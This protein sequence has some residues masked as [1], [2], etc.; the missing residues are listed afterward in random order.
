MRSITVGLTPSRAAVAILV[1]VLSL[2]LSTSFQ[3][4][5]STMNQ[6]TNQQATSFA[7]VQTY[8]VGLS[9][10]P[11]TLTNLGVNPNFDNRTTAIKWVQDYLVPIDAKLVFI[12]SYWANAAN[13]SSHFVAYGYQPNIAN[14]LYATYVEGINVAFFTQQWSHYYGCP[15]WDCDFTSAYPQALTANQSGAQLATGMGYKI[16]TP[17]FYDQY[18]TDIAQLYK[19]YGNYTNWIGFGEGTQGDSGFIGADCGCLPNSNFDNGSIDSYAHSQWFL[20]LVNSTGYYVGTN[21]L[22]KIWQMFDSPSPVMYNTTQIYTEMNTYDNGVSACGV[23]S[24]CFDNWLN[25]NIAYTMYNLTQFI[26]STYGRHMYYL[27]EIGVGGSGSVMSQIPNINWAYVMSSVTAGSWIIGCSPSPAPNSC[28]PAN[29]W[30]NNAWGSADNTLKQANQTNFMT[31]NSFGISADNA[32]DLTPFDIGQQAIQDWPSSGSGQIVT[33]NDY[34]PYSNKGI[35]NMTQQKY[36]QSFGTV[37]SRMVYDGGFFG[38]SKDAVRLLYFYH[39]PGSEAVLPE[40]LAAGI[41][42]TLVSDSYSDQNYTYLGNLKQYNVIF[43]LPR[44][45]TNGTNT[46]FMGRLESFIQ[47]GGGVVA[48]DLGIDINPTDSPS[49]YAYMQNILGFRIS[50]APTGTCTSDN[51][52]VASSSLVKPYTSISLCP[53]WTGNN[54]APLSNES[55]QVVVQTNTG[56]PVIT[57]NNYG[58]GRGVDIEA[59]GSANNKL[60]QPYASPNSWFTLFI[61]AV[62]FAAHKENMLP[63]IWTTTYGNQNWDKNLVYS[64]DG[65]PGK[66]VLIWV[67][68]NDTSPSHFDIHLNAA[69]YGISS[70][71][72]IAINM[73]NMSVIAKNSSSDIHISAVVQGESWLP[74]YIFNDTLSSNLEP[75]YSTASIVSSSSSSSSSTYSLDGLTNSSGWLVLR[76]DSP[77]ST[78]SSSL[79]NTIPSYPNLSSLNQTKIGSYCSQ[80]ISSAC[81]SWTTYGREGWY[82]DYADNLLYIHFEA[83]DPIMLTIDTSGMVTSTTS[84]STTSSTAESTTSTDTSGSVSSLS[85]T[86]TSKTTVSSSST[87]TTSTSTDSQIAVSTTTTST[88]S[89]T[90]T[91]SLASKSVSVTTSNQSMSTTSIH[92]SSSIITSTDSASTEFTQPNTSTTSTTNGFSSTNTTSYGASENSVTTSN[93]SNIAVLFGF[94]PFLTSSSPTPFGMAIFVY[95]V[96]LVT[97]APFILNRVAKSSKG[98]SVVNSHGWRW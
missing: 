28:Y 78:V 12:D 41:N 4:Q 81:T 51:I 33:F 5:P 23:P 55:S 20:Q 67:G 14:F 76:S 87:M 21:I 69:F 24:K 46:S 96:G 54:V 79:T 62:F 98:R 75:L 49:S 65:T 9:G 45:P 92:Q 59:F 50:G 86:T 83:S 56:A 88:T 44:N 73:Q 25:Y 8:G 61:N 35:L 18:R 47:N 30:Q 6:Q 97:S 95:E 38:T 43:G 39:N 74:I 27:T 37:L 91:N 93:S 68:N 16:V 89:A 3:F 7:S 71:G 22:S 52:I 60:V 72:W 48:N 15:S 1:V 77:P 13:T 90:V 32:G 70:T 11:V 40:L 26:Q 36:T 85:T 64:V 82:Y 58:S 53:Y 42:V 80:V 17:L 10:A 63:V 31:W 29:T 94:I 34:S 84:S 57:Y 2:S 66:P 19:W